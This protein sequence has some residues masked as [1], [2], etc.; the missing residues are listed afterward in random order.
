MD[1]TLPFSAVA[2][3]FGS[4]TLNLYYSSPSTLNAIS[5]LLRDTS[6]R[7]EARLDKGPS[8]LR[9]L[10]LGSG[11]GR[12]VVHMATHFGIRATGVDFSPAS[13]AEATENARLAGVAHLCD[14][15]L[16]DFMAWDRIPEEYTWVAAYLPQTV[17]FRLR[18]AVERWLKGDGA[19]SEGGVER[20]SRLFLSVLYEMKGWDRARLAG[21]DEKMTL[22]VA[23]K[24]TVPILTPSG[25]LSGNI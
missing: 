24:N 4:S 21:S 16:D 17:V 13:V 10:D 15:V 11:D 3:D 23:D 19:L 6:E 8:A 14:F 25:T 18:D 5:T 2:E 20:D 22:W 9:F 12:L 1:D 7:L